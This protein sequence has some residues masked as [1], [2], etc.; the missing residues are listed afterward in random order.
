MNHLKS[1]VSA[2][3]ILGALTACGTDNLAVMAPMNTVPMQAQPNNIQAQ[4]LSGINREMGKAVEASF[5]QKDTN[6]DKFIT[7]DEFP[8]KNPDDFV[9]FRKLDDNKD[10][11]LTV[12]ELGPGLFGKIQDVFQIRAMGNFLF[13]QLDRNNDNKLSKDEAAASTIPGLAANFAKF[14]GKPTFGNKKL[15]YLRKTDFEELVAFAM[16]NPA[17]ASSTPP[18]Q[19]APPPAPADPAQPPNPG[20]RR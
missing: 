12:K 17:A 4:S 11:K 16:L 10:G 3:F 5:K 18:S 8:V 7:P 9:A 14:L 20:A 1:L 15:D 2:A 6:G 13:D 19:P